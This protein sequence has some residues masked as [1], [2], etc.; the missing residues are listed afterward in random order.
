MSAGQ[1]WRTCSRTLLL[2]PLDATSPSSLSCAVPSGWLTLRGRLGGQVRCLRWRS[3]LPD[4]FRVRATHKVSVTQPAKLRSKACS[5]RASPSLISL[6]ALPLHSAWPRRWKRTIGCFLS[7]YNFY[8]GSL[9]GSLAYG[10][11]KLD[12]VVFLGGRRK[13]LVVFWGAGGRS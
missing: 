10:Q 9:A 3:R 6:S 1:V 2:L 8:F 7:P 13:G 4:V 11:H 12:L 5:P